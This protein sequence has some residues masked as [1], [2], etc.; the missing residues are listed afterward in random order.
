ML[1][2][3]IDML[4]PASLSDQS[5]GL[6]EPGHGSAPDIA[7]TNIANPLA[8][9]LSVAMMLRHSLEC[10]NLADAVDFVASVQSNVI[11]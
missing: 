9:I 7:G 6:W 11:D 8:T 10:P 1:T 2:G 5:R 3:S 4:A